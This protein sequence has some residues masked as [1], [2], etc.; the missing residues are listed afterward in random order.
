MTDTPTTMKPGFLRPDDAADYLSVSRRTLYN[1]TARG[2]VP[3]S[4]LG[5]KLTLYAVAD[6]DAAVKRYATPKIIHSQRN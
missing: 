1:L 5:P 4:R 6:L 3:A 2:V